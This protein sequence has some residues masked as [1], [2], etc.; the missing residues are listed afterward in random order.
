M[1]PSEFNLDR[2]PEHGGLGL[3]E[4]SCPHPTL[5]REDGK[6]SQY[7]VFH[8][9]PEDVP[10]EVD[11]CAALSDALE[12]VNND[13]GEKSPEHRGQFVGATFGAID[14]H[15][16]HIK[17]TD[18]FDIRFDHARFQTENANLDFEGATF[19]TEGKQP[20]SFAGAKFIAHGGNDVLFRNA[21]FRTD[22]EGDVLFRNATFRTTDRGTVGF[23]N[24]TFRTT[25]EG[26]VSFAGATFRT[27]GPGGVAFSHTTFR[28][29][30]EGNVDFYNSTFRTTG[31][32]AVGF[33]CATFRT[34]SEGDVEFPGATFQTD[35]QGSVVFLETTFRTTG[36]GDVD[37]R[38]ATYRTT[39]GGDVTFRDATL[40]NADFR[41]I[42]FAEADF[43][44][45]D[46]TATD[47]RGA[48]IADI[49]LN[50]AT[51]CERLN[52]GYG[53]DHSIGSLSVLSRLRG[54]YR[55]SQFDSEAWDA[56]AQAYHQLKIVFSKHGLVG[57]ARNMHVR[58][59][60]ARS[61]EAKAANGWFNGRYLRSLPSRVFTGYGV[62]VWNLVIWM[63]LLFA[64]STAIYVN[65]GVQDTLLNN[66]SYSVLAFTVAP[67]PPMPTGVGTQLTMMVETFFGT[68]S[69]VLLGYILGNRE[70]F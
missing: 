63:I 58:E 3:T 26:S 13:L 22:G 69:I 54:L 62:Q 70:R 12:S 19:V 24:S 48:N 57:G 65:A 1:E 53:Y 20:I 6:D 16:E 36:E 15:G 41:R 7:C 45:A 51:T 61:L 5:D 44:G 42:E 43:S 18:Q 60:Q 35:G 64:F 2:P 40:A 50:G 52:E 17:A 27:D 21:T 25:G 8:T 32:D 34:D 49:S 4:W 46:L 39:G 28:T 38:D 47:L 23:P 30:G 31:E 9:D 11:E 55:G 67:P 68:L 14:L 66:I 56:T 37:F 59:R 10:D 29:D 33:S